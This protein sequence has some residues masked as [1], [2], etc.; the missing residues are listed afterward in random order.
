MDVKLYLKLPLIRSLLLDESGT[1]NGVD[2]FCALGHNHKRAQLAI[3][4]LPTF[5]FVSSERNMSLVFCELRF[6]RPMD[7]LAV[8]F[9]EGLVRLEQA[10]AVLH[11][12]CFVGHFDLGDAPFLPVL[13]G[14]G[15]DSTGIASFVNGD[16]KC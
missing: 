6:A 7:L 10:V 2:I 3:I 9:K 4:C 12:K 13:N 5:G 8:G 1:H 15:N 16:A 11:M 14:S